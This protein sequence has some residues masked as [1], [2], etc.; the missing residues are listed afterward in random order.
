MQDKK[1]SS[2]FTPLHVYKIHSLPHVFLPTGPFIF[3]C[4]KDY[5]NDKGLPRNLFD[6]HEKELRQDCP[7]VVIH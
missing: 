1:G 3:S 7:K 5:S 4:M 6:F 2:K